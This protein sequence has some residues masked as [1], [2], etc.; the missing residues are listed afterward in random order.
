MDGNQRVSVGMPVYNGERYLGQ[1][2]ESVLAQTYDDLELIVADNASTDGT[3][4]ICRDYAARDRRLRYRRHAVNGGA[5]W[6][7]NYL[8]GEATGSLFKWIGSDDLCDPRFLACCVAQLEKDPEAVLA[9]P[10]TV[11]IDATGTRIRE[12]DPGW[13]LLSD[14]PYERLREV[15]MRGGH[16]MNADASLGVIRVDAL[17]RTRLLPRYQGGDKITLG[18]LSLQGKFLEVPEHLLYRRIHG[19]ASSQNNPAVAKYDRRSVE[20]MSEFFKGG[21]LRTCL[22]SWAL[23]GDHLITIWSSRLRPMHKA[24]LTGAVV[25]AGR[26]YQRFLLEELQTVGRM[27]FAAGG[28]RP[29][30]S[31]R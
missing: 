23:L 12:Y 31:A 25:R 19:G 7:H 1:A 16:W 9:Y 13:E 11:L 5:A 14:D 28:H 10:K 8:V 15:I 18:E 24:K 17:R 4:E 29:A 21:T 27:L 30:S 2:I 26:W 20:W 6:N 3:E 22:P